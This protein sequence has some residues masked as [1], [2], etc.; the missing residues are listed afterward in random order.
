MEDYNILNLN[1]KIVV[2]I[3]TI[4]IIVVCFC[5][6]SNNSLA[7]SEV[8]ENKIESLYFINE[9]VVDRFEELR[10]EKRNKE[11]AQ[12]I[13]DINYLLE[14]DKQLY[15]QKYRD[16]VELY[17]INQKTIKEVITD[18]EYVLLLKIGATEIGGGEFESMI[19]V[20]NVIINRV[21]L[22]SKYG[23][24]DTYDGVLKQ[25]NQF[26]SYSSGE[27]LNKEISQEIIDALDYAFMI[28]DIS[29]GATDFRNLKYC[30]DLNEEKYEK[31]FTDVDGH[32]F[33]K[34]RIIDNE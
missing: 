22:G 20:F 16:I 5:I 12:A 17:D 24:E 25:K 23:Y 28:G 15:I 8:T 11:F 10:Q 32:T 6:K 14:S 19:Y 26:S 3:L 7:V 30:K 4:I 18:E 27:Y 9:K 29:G 34:R 31:L 1:K 13:L 2:R 33:Y 21:L